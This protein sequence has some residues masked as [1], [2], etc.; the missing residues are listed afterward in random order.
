MEEEAAAAA[1]CSSLDGAGPPGQME[2]AAAAA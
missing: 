2:A 1:W